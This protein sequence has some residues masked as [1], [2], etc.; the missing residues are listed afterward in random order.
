M[1]GVAV[2]KSP[3]VVSRFGVLVGLLPQ[4]IVPT[5][6]AKGKFAVQEII[7]APEFTAVRVKAAAPE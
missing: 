6:E 4:L 7:P 2:D 5:I 3:V 1:Y